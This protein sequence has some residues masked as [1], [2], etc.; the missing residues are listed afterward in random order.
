MD[1]ERVTRV[2]DGQQA[3]HAARERR[4]AAEQRAK[5]NPTLWPALFH[6][7][8]ETLNTATLKFAIEG[9]LQ[10]DGITFFGGLAGHGKTLVMLNVVKALLEGADLFGYVPFKV[11]E[12]SKRVIYL[13]PESGLTPFVHRLKLFGLLDHVKA[14][15]LFFRTL[16]APEQDMALDDPR[17]LAACEGADVFLDTAVRFMSGDENS[18]SDHR[19]FAGTLF[20]LL[21]AGAR[22]VSGAH[23]SPKAFDGTKAM[24]L[25]S[26][27]RGSGDVG[28]MLSTAWAI[29]QQDFATNRLLVKNIKPRDFEP[30]QPFELE[31]RPWI[32][33]AGS[34][35]MI[36]QPGMVHSAPLHNAEKPE[37]TTARR[38]RAEGKTLTDIATAL[39][40]QPRTVERWSS[41][42]KLADTDTPT[43]VGTQ[44]GAA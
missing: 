16:S 37:I 26:A 42:G 22:T 44:G 29:K 15:R 17:I 21:R 25:E 36:A 6:S 27:L 24:T 31:G 2:W 32:D 12:V 8:E 33:T 38:M 41:K 23:H 19:A 34:F 5:Q 28:A 18:A 30:C 11:T 43:G 13:V 14:E 10:A 40:V 4:L 9:F 1:M 39:G 3:D 35:K 20:N 7:Y